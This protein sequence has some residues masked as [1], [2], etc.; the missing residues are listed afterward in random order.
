MTT[1]EDCQRLIDAG[2]YWDKRANGRHYFSFDYQEESRETF[3]AKMID[4]FSKIGIV[5]APHIDF[6]LFRENTEFMMSI[7]LPPE[8][9]AVFSA[10][11]AS[12]QFSV[13]LHS[14]KDSE[15]PSD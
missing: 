10:M 7:V 4:L 11:N 14:G 3:S 5:E 12:V 6:G 1:P 15:N 9:L 8:L 2:W 13:Y